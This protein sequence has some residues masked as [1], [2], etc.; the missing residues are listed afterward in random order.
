MSISYI[1]DISTAVPEHSY[2]QEFALEFLCS[3]PSFG[4]EER[5]FLKRLYSG[6]GIDKRHT[7]ISDYGKQPSQYQFFPPS[8]D[9]KPEP[10]L[11][12]R[13]NLFVAEADRLSVLAAGGI[14]KKPNGPDPSSV[15][16]LITV[17]CTG[18]SAPGFSFRLVRDL[19]LPSSVQRY[20]I[21]FM[22]CYAAIPALKLAD[23]ICRADPASR[24]L[25]VSV[26]LCSVH[27]QQRTDRE[28]MVAH[29]LFA[30][31][32][33]ACLVSGET[34]TPPSPAFELKGFLSK[35]L[36]DSEEAM[37]WTIGKSAFDMKLSVYV[38]QEIK[39]SITA[40]L[41]ELSANA[42]IK[43]SDFDLW[44]I[45]PGG[46]AILDTVASTLELSKDDL[47]ASYEVLRHYGNMSSATILFVLEKLL[48]APQTGR[49]F[50]AAFGP[51]LTVESAY[52]EKG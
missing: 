20:H 51:G 25:I 52:L 3:L 16:H 39:K 50:A 11:E 42:G 1:N 22:G 47:W 35:I 46:R 29:S 19:R 34:W 30:D 27:F 4:K 7:V 33:A 2:S 36:D 17:S 44:A 18:F 15:T 48:Q 31:G 49:V 9:L 28:T 38:P 6:T 23:T 12:Q 5:R 8:P 40:I 13:N 14:F 10:G 43:R 26:E 21:G 45:H 24:V 41:E 37:A 32:A